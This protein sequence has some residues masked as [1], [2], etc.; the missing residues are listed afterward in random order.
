MPYFPRLPSTANNLLQL[1]QGYIPDEVL[2]RQQGQ[3]F[4]QPAPDGQWWGYRQPPYG[5]GKNQ[6]YGIGEE[7]AKTPDAYPYFMKM[8]GLPWGESERAYHPTLPEEWTATLPVDREL[9]QLWKRK[10]WYPE[11]KEAAAEFQRP[12]TLEEIFPADRYT[13]E[14]IRQMR[15]WFGMP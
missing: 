5:N 7:A 2:N 11:Q 9:Q 12:K 13:N 4:S 10:G 1:T 8:P 15:P 6:F 3:W 14:A